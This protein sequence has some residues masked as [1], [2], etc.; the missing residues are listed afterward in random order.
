[1]STAAQLP[2]RGDL[3]ARGAGAQKG[4]LILRHRA[5]AEKEINEVFCSDHVCRVDGKG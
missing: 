4:A 3:V 1:M 5:N 2:R